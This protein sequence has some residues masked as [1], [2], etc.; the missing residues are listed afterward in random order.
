MFM[1]AQKCS[2]LISLSCGGLP[3]P[4]G[5]AA[6]L[7]RMSIRPKAETT[8]ATM[9]RTAASSPVSLLKAA[10]F[11]PVAAAIS[12]RAASSV[13]RSRATMATLAPSFASANAMALP[14]PR[15]PPVTMAALP[16]S[17]RSMLALSP[18]VSFACKYSRRIGRVVN[19][20]GR[21]HPPGSNHLIAQGR[22]AAPHA[23]K[24]L[25]KDVD[26][27]ILVALRLARRVGRDEDV[28]HGPERRSGG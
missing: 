6:Q 5:W 28:G 27:A 15:L 19:T 1:S 3:C 20:H 18:L 17:S 23:L 8:S 10:T 21:C 12:V 22:F 26:H 13:A 25:Q 16:L 7:T 24:V 14:M 2:L 9:P 11:T 4:P